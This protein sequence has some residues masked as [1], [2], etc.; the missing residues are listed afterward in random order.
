M[1][2]VSEC[3]GAEVH[4]CMG[5][6]TRERTVTGCW[7]AC[8]RKRRCISACVHESGCPRTNGAGV[9]EWASSDTVRY[10]AVGVNKDKRIDKTRK[11]AGLGGVVTRV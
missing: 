2:R 3:V 8:I 10:E 4:M 9:Q 11:G 5:A 1:E 7:R 6:Y